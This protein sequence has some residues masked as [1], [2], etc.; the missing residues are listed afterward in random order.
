MRLV[1]Q[2]RKH[3]DG[4]AKLYLDLF[5]SRVWKPFADAAQP[6]QEWPEVQ[7]SL[8]RLRPLAEEALLAVFELVMA[9][10]IETVVGRELPRALQAKQA[11]QSKE[12]G[13]QPKTQRGP[14]GDA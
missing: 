5:M 1:E 7:Q 3:A 9:E 2:L 6:D 8:Q 13:K 10:S 14:A 12:S 11:R 4:V